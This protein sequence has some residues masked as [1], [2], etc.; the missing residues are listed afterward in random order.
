[1]AAAAAE[2]LLL[3]CASLLVMKGWLSRVRT[4]GRWPGSLRS[5]ADGQE[6]HAHSEIN[7]HK[8]QAMRMVIAKGC[9]RHDCGNVT[10]GRP[11]VHGFSVPQDD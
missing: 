9:C 7:R 11:L 2:L 5:K 10:E 4:D 3:F 6:G 1:M 8:G